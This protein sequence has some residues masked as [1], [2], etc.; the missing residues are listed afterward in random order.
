MINARKKLILKVGPDKIGN[1]TSEIPDTIYEIKN[2][3][4]AVAYEPE[5]NV[6][7][8]NCVFVACRD[9]LVGAIKQNY[10]TKDMNYSATRLIMFKCLPDDI[11]HRR[12][13]MAKTLLNNIEK[14]NKWIRSKM[15][16]IN[17]ITGHPNIKKVVAGAHGQAEYIVGSK[18]WI[19]NVY[20]FYA[21]VQILRAFIEHGDSLKGVTTLDKFAKAVGRGGKIRITHNYGIDRWQE[22]FQKRLSVFKG[23]STKDM[24]SIGSIDGIETLCVGRAKIEKVRV[25]A[26]EAIG[27]V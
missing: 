22:L 12:V 6:V 27:V 15:Y 23:V 14:K 1:Y 24:Y 17:K 4:F 19:R 18:C 3:Y 11:L 26:A 10:L 20:F 25:R 8:N 7:T 9:T 13:L 2:T 16:K 21:Y 5:D